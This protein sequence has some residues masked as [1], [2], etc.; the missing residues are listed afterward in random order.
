[1][2]FDTEAVNPAKALASCVAQIGPSLSGSPTSQNHQDLIDL[3][4]FVSSSTGIERMRNAML[5]M[6]SQDLFFYTR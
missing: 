5:Q 2:T 3:V 4:F 1:M 6:L